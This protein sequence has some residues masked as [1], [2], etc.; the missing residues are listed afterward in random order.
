VYPAF[1]IHCVVIPVAKKQTTLSSFFKT[2]ARHEP[3]LE[4]FDEIEEIDDI[5]SAK[6]L[7]AENDMQVDDSASRKRKDIRTKENS[8]VAKKRK[9][10]NS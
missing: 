4:E 6:L 8:T 5:I 10:E 2:P 7:P 3:V 9:N 1:F